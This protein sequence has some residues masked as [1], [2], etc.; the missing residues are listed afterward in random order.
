MLQSDQGN[1]QVLYPELSPNTYYRVPVGGDPSHDF[2]EK[3]C[4]NL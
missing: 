3:L 1:A 4:A 2:W